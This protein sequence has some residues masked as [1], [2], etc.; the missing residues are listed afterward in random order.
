MFINLA[1]PVEHFYL[2]SLSPSEQVLNSFKEE[3]APKNAILQSSKKENIGSTSEGFVKA[4]IAYA[5]RSTRAMTRSMTKATASITLKQPAVAPTLQ[6]HKTQ[7]FGFNLP[8]D[9][10]NQTA[11]LPNLKLKPLAIFNIRK[12]LPCGLDEF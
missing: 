9:G 4:S 5:N 2:S 11:C 3:M 6:S 8:T 10:I 7:N 1:R 12:T